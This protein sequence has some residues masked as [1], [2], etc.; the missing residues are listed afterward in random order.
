MLQFHSSGALVPGNG[1]AHRGE[2]DECV[3]Q[4][5]RTR[6]SAL[7][8]QTLIPQHSAEPPELFSIRWESERL[9]CEGPFLSVASEAGEQLLVPCSTHL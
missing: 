4:R 8:P 5:I 1:P 6:S 2:N 3:T 9:R 7:P